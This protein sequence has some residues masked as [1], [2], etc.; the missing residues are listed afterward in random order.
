MAES[1]LL[2]GEGDIAFLHALDGEIVLI[3]VEVVA[4]EPVLVDPHDIVGAASVSRQ[5][6][7][8]GHTFLWIV[9]D[10]QVSKGS[11][12]G[13]GGKGDL[14]TCVSRPL[15]RFAHDWRQRHALG[16]QPAQKLPQLC[17]GLGRPELCLLG[18]LARKA[19][20][21]RFSA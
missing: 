6:E 19:S 20:S 18:G 12:A 9:G 11:Q 4:V 17:S 10:Q 13:S 2:Q 16:W 21:G 7:D 8:C 1:Q 14:T 3:A 15:H 5:A